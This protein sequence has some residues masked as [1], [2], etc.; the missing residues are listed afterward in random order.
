MNQ[1]PTFMTEA[2]T[3]WGRV[4]ISA[5]TSK[6]LPPAERVLLCEALG[7]VHSAIPP[8]ISKDAMLSVLKAFMQGFDRVEAK[9]LV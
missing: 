6:P 2:D 5:W 8:A 4:R 3:P 1:P 9:V 7:K